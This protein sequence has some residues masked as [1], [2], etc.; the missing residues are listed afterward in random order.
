MNGI[1][2]DMKAEPQAYIDWIHQKGAMSIYEFITDR[3][4]RGF[5]SRAR[6]AGG[7]PSL[8]WLFVLSYWE[9]L[10]RAGD[11]GGI[12]PVLKAFA[13]QLNP[14]SFTVYADVLEKMRWNWLVSA[15]QPFIISDDPV[16][17][18]GPESG[19]ACGLQRR[20]VQVFIPLSRQLCLFMTHSNPENASVIHVGRD[21]V[22]NINRLQIMGA[23]QY[24]YGPSE[25]DLW[26]GDGFAEYGIMPGIVQRRVPSRR[27]D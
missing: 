17:R 26:V 5:A 12:P 24:V 3:R 11:P 15:E 4:N 13:N 18:S 22:L 8:S 19:F 25:R 2:G 27:H 9:M 6:D 10:V 7:S 14:D 16:C 1:L 23:L 21:A 20:D